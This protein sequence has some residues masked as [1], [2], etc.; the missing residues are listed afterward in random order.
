MYIVK[1]CSHFVICSKSIFQ[2]K[3]RFEIISSDYLNNLRF[4]GFSWK[5]Q[6][7]S[8]PPGCSLICSLAS[9][10]AGCLAALGYH[11]VLFS[12]SGLPPHKIT[13][14]S[15]NVAIK[16]GLKSLLQTV[17]ME[18]IKNKTAELYLWNRDKGDANYW[19]EVSIPSL[20]GMYNY[21]LF[22]IHDLSSS[23][24]LQPFLY[25]SPIIT[26]AG[27]LMLLKKW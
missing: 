25:F 1:D 22:N 17:N 12:N 27:V 8:E 5:M 11:R 15:F 20:I 23:S 13:F 21:W 9:G 6:I 7:M 26:F 18:L 2:E 19:L 16:L 4:S 14:Q 10:C 24:L 3:L